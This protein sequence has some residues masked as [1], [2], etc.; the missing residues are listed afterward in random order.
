MP[1][2]SPEL[3]N[4]DSHFKSPSMKYL[5]PF[6]LRRKVLTVIIWRDESSCNGHGRKK[7]I[8]ELLGKTRE[9]EVAKFYGVS[10]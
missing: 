3:L 9:S 7:K 6:S 4:R 5:C 10:F 1:L 2:E 8:V